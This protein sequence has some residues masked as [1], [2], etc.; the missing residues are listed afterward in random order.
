M[1]LKLWEVDVA[2]TKKIEKVFWSLIFFLASINNAFA[3]MMLKGATKV[4]TIFNFYHQNGDEGY[5]VYN[6]PG[7]EEVNVVEPMIFMEHQITDETAINANFIVDLWTAASDTKLDAQ[8]GASGA[9]RT[10]QSRIAGNLGF[11]TETGKW[12]YSSALGISSEYDYK[13]INGSVNVSR[14]FAKD[15]FTLGLG[16]QYYLDEVSL[17]PSLSNP[18]AATIQ[19]GFDR[20]I[21]ATSIS[22]SQILTRRDI[23][24]FTLNYIRASGRLESTAS[25]VNVGGLREV[26]RLPGERNRYALSSTW[27]HAFNA[28]HALNSSYRYYWDDWDMSA[29][30]ARLAYLWEY[31]EAGDLLEFSTR[32]HHQ[33]GVKYFKQRF[34]QSEEFMTSDSDMDQFDS[35]ELGLYNSRVLLGGDD[36]KVFGFDFENLNWSNGVTYSTRSNGLKYAYWQTAISFEF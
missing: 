28:T 19:D 16:L 1:A 11:R 31:N 7:R 33:S 18:T 14:S 26:E 32:F 9:G 2:V 10:N 21:L 20:K 30:T 15:N 22:A 13:S 35:I 8:T 5:Q 17:F 25:S 3:E 12:S 24:L 23:A 34:G 27:V 4:K 29:H 36:F 6:G